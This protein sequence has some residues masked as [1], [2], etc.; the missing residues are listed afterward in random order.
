[1][2]ECLNLKSEDTLLVRGGTCALGY[3]SIQIAKA[4]GCQVI[5]TTHKEEKIHLLFEAGADKVLLDDG[6]LNDKVNGVTKALELV[7]I[8]TIKDTLMAV[9]KGGIVCNTGILGGIFAWNGFDPIKDIPNGVYLTGFYSNTPTQKVVNAIFEFLKV[10]QLKP[11]L[12]KVFQFVYCCILTYT[13]KTGI[14][15]NTPKVP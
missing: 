9:E 5:A 15:H 11:C 12:G 2:F 3:A 4:L 6:N 14:F 8:K 10:H 1:M 13:F 7:G